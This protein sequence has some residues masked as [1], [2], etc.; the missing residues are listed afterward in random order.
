MS[1]S[2]N[3]VNHYQVRYLGGCLEPSAVGRGFGVAAGVGAQAATISTGTFVSGLAPSAGGGF[4]QA[5]D[6]DER[7]AFDT[8]IEGGSQSVA[9]RVDQGGTILEAAGSL[10]IATGKFGTAIRTQ[11]PVFPENLA[12]AEATSFESFSVQG[13]GSVEFRLDLTGSWDVGGL[14][15]LDPDFSAVILRAD[16]FV[17]ELG[18][19]DGARPRFLVRQG[20]PDSQ[21]SG[22]VSERLSYVQQV[23]D[24]KSYGFNTT[25]V[26]SLERTIGGGTASLAGALLLVASP[27]VS[28]DFSD[29]AFLSEAVPIPLPASAFLLLGSLGAVSAARLGRSLRRDRSAPA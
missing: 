7:T 19:A 12:F 3:R 23:L 20:G 29:P 9:A 25:V 2:R 15:P 17:S 18:S 22:T 14:N 8:A 6:F 16:F 5:E 11:N 21:L 4:E 28:I 26:S 24:G 10:D 13:S 1:A 27:G